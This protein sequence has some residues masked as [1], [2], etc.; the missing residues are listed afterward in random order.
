MIP[1]KISPEVV[2]IAE[3]TAR[4]R[5][6]KSQLA[7]D[8]NSG[9]VCLTDN[10]FK[11]LAASSK[12]L[13]QD[14]DMSVSVTGFDDALG[15]GSGPCADLADYLASAVGAT[16]C[17]L[18]TAGTSVSNYSLG[19]VLERCFGPD[20]CV[21]IEAVSHGSTLGGFSSTP[22]SV[23]MLN[24]EFD[25]ERQ[26]ALPITAE[27]LRLALDQN[28]EVKAVCLVEPSY[29]GVMSPDLVGIRQ[30][31]SERNVALIVD[32]AWGPL[33]GHV[34]GFPKSAAGLADLTTVS[35]HKKGLGNSQISAVYFN[36]EELLKAFDEV[37]DLGLASTSPAYNLISGLSGELACMTSEEGMRIYEKAI[38][39]AQDVREKIQR[40]PG[41]EVL[42]FRALGLEADPMHILIDTRKSR[43]TGFQILD[44]MSVMGWDVEKAT[45]SS[46]LLLWGPDHISFEAELVKT[47]SAALKHT[48]PAPDSFELDVPSMDAL[49]GEQVLTPY[50]AFFGGHE[51]ERVPLEQAVGRIAAGPLAAYP[52]GSA[53]LVPGQ[54]VEQPAVE[55]LCKVQGLGSKLKGAITKDGFCVLKV[56]KGDLS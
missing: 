45:P 46:V 49:Q 7:C 48:A 2:E 29:D 6:K 31:C 34:T 16:A 53:I 43:R 21:L 55:F 37:A 18:Q 27:N 26:I 17:R 1:Y 4:L 12:V 44:A 32:G 25:A 24:R 42:D 54:R 38:R 20:Y 3:A 47:L 23:K 22:C 36:N 50:Q 30:L 41:L 15:R 10:D 19:K 52:P 39:S 8:L 40:L 35:L 28:P 51:I 56:L 13:Q 14:E 5:Q 9:A 33:H 11:V